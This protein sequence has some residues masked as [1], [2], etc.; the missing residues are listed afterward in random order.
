MFPLKKHN[1]MQ[2]SGI[3]SELKKYK[4]ITNFAKK[5]YCKLRKK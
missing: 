1:I 5:T 4:H 2:K 3:Y